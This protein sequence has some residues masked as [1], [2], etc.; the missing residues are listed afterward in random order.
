MGIIVTGPQVVEVGI[1]V[2]DV[3]AVA[4]GVGFSQGGGHGAGG[5]DG[6]AP[7]VV[8]VLHHCRAGA[9]IVNRASI[10]AYQQVAPSFF[11]FPRVNFLFSPGVICL[12]GESCKPT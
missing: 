1:L 7:G 6:I 10:V 4:Q 9:I 8:G 5:A 11:L 2:V 12:D 3:A